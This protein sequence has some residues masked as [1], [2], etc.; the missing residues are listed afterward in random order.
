LLVCYVQGVQRSPAGMDL[1]GYLTM[2]GAWLAGQ[3]PYDVIDPSLLARFHVPAAYT[4]NYGTLPPVPPHGLPLLSLFAWLPL[5]A[6]TLAVWTTSFLALVG[7]L[8]LL[9][10]RFGKDWSAVERLL[11]VA[12]VAQSRLIQSI[13]YRGQIGVILFFSLL[14]ALR[15]QERGR[16]ILAGV[17]VAITLMK[18]TL[19]VPLL[20]LLLSRRAF[21]TLFAS[22]A[23]AGLVG[24]LAAIPAGV[25]VVLAAYPQAVD[26]FITRDRIS[27]AGNWHLTSWQAIVYDALGTATPAANAVG[28]VLTAVA[29]VATAIIVWRTR[30]S[31][32]DGW[33][34]ATFILL[35]QVF[36]YHRVYDGIFVF[37][38]V[39]LLWSKLRGRR[40]RT[41]SAMEV[42]TAALTV[43]FVFVLS[44]QS[45][46]EYVSNLVST[47]P[48]GS[49][50]NAWVSLLLFASVALLAFQA[51]EP[52][53]APARG[54]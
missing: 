21:G 36:T 14:L 53:G 28:M 54:T 43:L 24:L 35:A 48:T 27:W 20:A 44:I 23:I 11:F 39:A 38:V 51:T 1:R 4:A 6:A 32:D 3:N 40:L 5:D 12:V 16:P 31:K 10:E 13:A 41:L 42:V 15:Y 19:G 17:F 52:H 7:A 45:V 50:V 9:V 46:S 33:L 29:L 26:Q 49:A 25:R 8:Y 30:A 22:G 2:G 47:V 18:P 37:V 34:F